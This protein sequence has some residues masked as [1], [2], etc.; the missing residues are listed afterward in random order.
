[1]QLQRLLARAT[2]VALLWAHGLGG[3]RRMTRAMMGLAMVVSLGCAPPRCPEL[4]AAPVFAS[5]PFGGPCR[6]T[7]DCAA[8]LDCLPY[9]DGLSLCSRVCGGSVG[10]SAGT[11][12][13]AAADA[14]VGLCKAA[15]QGDGGCATGLLVSTCANGTCI[16]T[17][18]ST[19]ARQPNDGC[20]EGSFCAGEVCTEV[21]EGGRVTG[22]GVGGGRCFVNP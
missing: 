2:P 15:C 6:L 21:V 5:Q 1:M 17:F 7:A 22:V 19:R 12:L 13:L 20:P 9:S 14:G 11:C 8:G 16:P 4:P 18:C 3:S 10:C